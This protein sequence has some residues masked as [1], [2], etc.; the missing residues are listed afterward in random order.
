MFTYRRVNERYYVQGRVGNTYREVINLLNRAE[1]TIISAGNL[2][3]GGENREKEK[4]TGDYLADYL[5]KLVDNTNGDYAFRPVVI[6]GRL[7][8]SADWLQRDGYATSQ[9]LVE[10]S[11]IEDADGMY[12]IDGQ[13]A[14][15][16][17]G[18][19]NGMLRTAYVIDSDSISMYGLRDGT[20]N[21]PEKDTR[22]SVLATL[23]DSIKKRAWPSATF[24]F[25]VLDVGTTWSRLQLGY[26]YPLLM[27]SVGFGIRKTVRIESMYYDPRRGK[28]DCKATEVV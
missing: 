24:A 12:K 18:A 4:L 26:N 13:F 3:T 19:T 8:I 14:N 11:N 7:T 25:G 21:F 27:W 9:P 2:W 6:G 10:S 17:T 15:K 22:A 20:E 1:P 23:R 16:L 28:V 5:Q